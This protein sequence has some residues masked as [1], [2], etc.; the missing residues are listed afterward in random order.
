MRPEERQKEQIKRRATA[1]LVGLALLLSGVGAQLYN[2]QLV[3]TQY[4]ERQAAGNKFRRIYIPAARGNIYDRNGRLLAGNRLTYAVSILYTSQAEI[5]EQTLPELALI[6]A[7]GDEERAAALIA[8]MKETIALADQQVGLFVP[9]RVATDIPEHIYTHIWEKRDRLPGVNIEVIPVRDY[10]PDELTAHITGYVQQ[11]SAEDLQDPANADL[12]PGDMI[13]RTGLE[14]QYEH[15]LRG[16]TGMRPVEVDAVGHFVA[17]L[18]P[19]PPVPGN[20]LVTTLDLNLQRAATDAMLRH[21]ERI[22]NNPPVDGRPNTAERGALVVLDVNTG[23]V[24]AMVSVPSYK[25]SQFVAGEVD[26]DVLL[27]P[28]HPLINKAIAASYSPASTYKMLSAI[29]GLQEG[30]ITP[31]QVIVSTPRYWRYD[32][33]REW[34][35]WGLGPM[36]AVRAIAMSSDIYFYEVGHLLGPDRLAKW[37]SHFGFGEP[38]GID[39]PGEVG[40]IN[41]TL[42]S[43]GDDWQPGL[44]VRL[45]IGQGNVEATMLQLANYTATIA[46]GGKRW[47]PYLVQEIR[48]VSGEVLE[49]I[50]PE[51]IEE[52]PVDPEYIRIAQQ[53]MAQVVEPG[54][55]S[56]AF[57]EP[58]PFPIKVAGKTGTAEVGGMLPYNGFFV[59]YAP[60][61]NP[62]I[63]IALFV[64]GSGGGSYVAPI[65]R[66]VFQAYFEQRGRLP[67][68]EPLVEAG[69]VTAP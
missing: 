59:A 28:H 15:V 63:A 31:W 54:G 37:A 7:E 41:P 50:E 22:R 47:R 25:P 60:Y 6:L 16:Q 69:G 34:S 2:L 56:S 36:N 61:E 65:A 46:N 57:L 39:L 49:R 38:T 52:V 27:S 45:T 12:R 1:L 14:A 53:G 26:P 21:M 5:E 48:D 19:E 20:N 32:Q 24:L 9:V 58:T 23:A 64:E 40:G 17:E 68:H 35:P 67:R 8:E 44:A 10:V 13:G 11:V 18:E 66:D 4:W 62:E 3:Q 42:A 33:P 30:V 29:A 51:L 55:T 43:Y